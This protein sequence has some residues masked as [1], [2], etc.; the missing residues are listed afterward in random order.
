MEVDFGAQ[1][2]IVTEVG[3]EPGESRVNINAGP[4]PGY[5][6]VDGERMPQ[7]VGSRPDSTAGRFEPQ[8]T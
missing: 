4:V 7:I 8:A 2:V 6:A 5:E 1:D 3:G